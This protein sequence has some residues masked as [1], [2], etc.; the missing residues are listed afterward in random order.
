[1]ATLLAFWPVPLDEDVEFVAVLRATS[2]AGPYEQIAYLRARDGYQ[3]WVTH[4]TDTAAPASSGVWYQ[5]QYFKHA[6]ATETVSELT[7]IS[8]PTA[9]EIP[10]SVTPQMVLDTIQGINMARVEAAAVQRVLGWIVEDMEYRIR[11]DLSTKVVAGE[12]HGHEAFDRIIGNKVGQG[13]QLRHFPVQSV[14]A[15]KYSVRGGIA[16]MTT[17]QNLDIRILHNN[18]TNGYNRGVVS[19]WPRVTSLTSIFSGARFVSARYQNALAITFD[20]THGWTTWPG[21]LMQNISQAA[22]SFIMEI[23]G[24]ASTAGISSRSIDGYAE[25]FTASATTTIFSARR[26]FYLEELKKAEARYK[27]SIWA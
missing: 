18:P 8:L 21:G 10:Y 26:I 1:M 14:E 22:A 15:V 19:I 6:D 4:Y 27:K 3:N 23:A 7:E 16:N 25:A 13:I 11:M 12:E 5:V 9:G 20:Y 24:E 17:M 2:E